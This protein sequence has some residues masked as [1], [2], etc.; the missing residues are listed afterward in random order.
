MNPMI[1]FRPMRPKLSIPSLAKYDGPL[2]EGWHWQPKLDDERGV[3]VRW[4]ETGGGAMGPALYNRH[5]RPI[6]SNKAAVFAPAVQ[7]LLDLFPD[8][9]L[10]DVALLGYRGHWPAGGI[11]LLDLPQVEDDWR[12]RQYAIRV[13]LTWWDP[14]GQQ[15]NPGVGD[16]CRLVGHYGDRG[17]LFRLFAQ[18]YRIPGIE[19][20]IGRD[21]GARYMQGDSD[22]MCK[23]KW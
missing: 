13:L 2:P 19:G 7:R 3:V 23:I 10:F 4:T 12:D 14:L 21:P 17:D 6:A 11:V 8:Q 16:V 1:S 15:K 18:T 5:G 22:R 9:D 20:L